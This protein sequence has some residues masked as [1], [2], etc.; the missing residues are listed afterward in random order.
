[1]SITN[2]GYNRKLL[3][4][5]K[6]YTN[7][8]KY[9]NHNHSLTFRLAIFY[10]ICF[11]ANVLPEVKIKTFHIIFKSPILDYYSSNISINST[12][13]NSIQVCYLTR[14]K[15]MK[16]DKTKNKIDETKIGVGWKTL[17]GFFK[18]FYYMITMIIIKEKGICQSKKDKLGHQ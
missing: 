17:C 10:D 2:T 18:C 12:D 8:A 6:I 16:W 14:M 3:N 1:M 4:L 5:T 9:S 13:I 7:D 15:L 11:R